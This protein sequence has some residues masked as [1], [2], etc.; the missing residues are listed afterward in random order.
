MVRPE[1][2]GFSLRAAGSPGMR[3]LAG[4][5]YGLDRG[6]RNDLTAYFGVSYVP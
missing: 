6:Y 4:T 2:R 3:L 5:A 1:R